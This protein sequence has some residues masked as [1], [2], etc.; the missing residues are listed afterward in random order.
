MF[1]SLVEIRKHLHQNPELSE[2]EVNTAEFIEKQII[3]LK[4][5]SIVKIGYSRIFIFDSKNRGLNIAF[6][7]DMDALPIEEKNTIAHASTIKGVG[8][9]CGHDG[10][11]SILMGFAREMAK[12]PPKKGKV[13]LVFQSAE[14]TG[15]G[16]KQLVESEAFQKLNIDYIF[17]LHNMPG[18]ELG[19]VLLRKGGFASASRGMIVQL[20]GKTSHAGK[21]EKGINP[22]LAV[23]QITQELN[24]LIN[25]KDYYKSL[26]LLTFIY[27]KL[28]EVA[29][30]TSAGHAEMGFTLRSFENADM[31]LLVEDA[32]RI[33]YQTAKKYQL[34]TGVSYTEEFPG[35]I[36]TEDAFNRMLDAALKLKMPIFE[37]EEPSRWSEDFGNYSTIAKTGFFGLGSGIEQP[38]LHHP[39]YDFPDEIIEKGV[40][41]FLKILQSFQ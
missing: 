22:A 20:D 7:A 12:N 36:S 23:A 35:T 2:Q 32:E 34:K 18:F 5:D 10:H 6:R 16:A 26:T 3:P 15:Q 29:F 33:I 38:E 13:I 28:G 19:Q 30:G 24:Q 21:P 14:E 40:S 37:L 41:I 9:L 4:P 31:E 1:E 8:H 25:Q 39:D 17:G 11:M 27:I